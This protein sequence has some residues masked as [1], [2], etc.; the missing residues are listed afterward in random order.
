MADTNDD[1]GKDGDKKGGLK[2]ERPDGAEETEAASEKGSGGKLLALLVG[3][4]VIAFAIALGGYEYFSGRMPG[5]GESAEQTSATPN[6]GGPFTLVNHKGETVTDEDFRGRYMMVYFG[7]TYCP[8]VCPTSL[9]DMATAL[10]MLADEKA[11]KVTP[12]FISVDPARDTPEHLAEYVEFFHPRL[13]GLTGTEQQI[14]DVAREYR[15]YYR[16]NEP[17]GDDP[18]DYLVDHTSIIYLVGPDGKLVTHFSHGTSP[19]AMAERLGKL[20]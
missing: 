3:V 11:E 13:V 5:G 18:L 19:E 8:D 9:T 20:L 7:Y 6:V 2:A 17:S 12:V 4:V 14:K 10:D 1:G 15:V 16:L